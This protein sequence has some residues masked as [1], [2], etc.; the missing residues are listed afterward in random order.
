MPL[1]LLPTCCVMYAGGGSRGMEAW[2]AEQ[3][4]NLSLKAINIKPPK[5][6][7]QNNIAPQPSIHP[8]VRQSVR[9][10]IISRCCWCSAHVVVLSFS[11]SFSCFYVI[12]ESVTFIA[13]LATLTL[14]LSQNG[15]K[16]NVKQKTE[17]ETSSNKWFSLLPL[18][19]DLHNQVCL[20]FCG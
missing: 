19:P 17:N 2:Y 9:P 14:A 13:L 12:S 15:P 4:A 10:S 5:V 11:F 6:F 16:K 3:P 18:W 1:P 20:T 8:F 7:Q